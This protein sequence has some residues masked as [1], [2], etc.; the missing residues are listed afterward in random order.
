MGTGGKVGTK[1]KMA[2]GGKKKMGYGGKTMKK[3]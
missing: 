2:Y 3:K 1:K